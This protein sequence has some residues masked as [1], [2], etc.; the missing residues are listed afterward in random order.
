MALVDNF[1]DEEFINIYNTSTSIAD[2]CPKLGYQ[3]R[4]SSNYKMI[5]KR[6]AELNLTEEK[7]SNSHR[8]QGRIKRNPENIFIK[9]S[10]ADQKTLRKY[11]LEGKYTPYNCSI[12]GQE[13]VWQGQPMALILDHINGINRDDRLEN[14]RWVCPN[15]NQQLPSTGIKNIKYRTQ[16]E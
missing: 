11:Y 5:R 3:H 10:T 12:C 16:F 8:F 15:C 9:N 14:L 1:T 7:F 4:G 2:M 13:P 6:M